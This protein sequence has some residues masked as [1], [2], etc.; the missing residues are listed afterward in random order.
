MPAVQTI[1]SS[2]GGTRN[3]YP[4]HSCSDRKL[5]KNLSIMKK[6]PS[7]AKVPPMRTDAMF[8]PMK[9]EASRALFDAS[10]CQS[11][12]FAPAHESRLGGITRGPCYFARSSRCL[13]ILAESSNSDSDKGNQCSKCDAVSIGH[14]NSTFV[15]TAGDNTPFSLYKNNLKIPQARVIRN[16]LHGK[17]H[18][19]RDS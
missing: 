6:R 17:S 14:S 1:N 11:F 3:T 19:C 13:S 9:L 16:S 7:E 12:T 4:I 5:S 8:R 18:L 10:S 15:M 2:K